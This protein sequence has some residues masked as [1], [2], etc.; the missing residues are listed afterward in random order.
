MFEFPKSN[1]VNQYIMKPAVPVLYDFQNSVPLMGAATMHSSKFVVHLNRLY[2]QL[3]G[4]KIAYSKELTC[5]LSRTA[6]QRLFSLKIRFGLDS[7]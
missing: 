2:K 1:I 3:L 5:T 7:A 6:L 4:F